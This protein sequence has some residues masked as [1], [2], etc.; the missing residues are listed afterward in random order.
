[1]DAEKANQR[2]VVEIDTLEKINAELVATLKETVQ[3]QKEG[4]GQ[5]RG[6]PGQ[7]APN[8]VRPQKRLCSK[9]PSRCEP[10]ARQQSSRWRS[11][12]ERCNHAPVGR[13]I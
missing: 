9:T 13:G 8:R 4:K 6:R 11:L 12:R 2:S 7:D 3:I 5:P 10:F 1:M